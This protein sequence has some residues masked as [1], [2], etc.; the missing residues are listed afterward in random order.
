LSF[1]GG[2]IILQTYISGILANSIPTSKKGKERLLLWKKKIAT[3]VYAERKRLHDSR[4][5]YAAYCNDKHYFR[6]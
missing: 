3:E 4:K 6:F 5:I 2:E 1:L